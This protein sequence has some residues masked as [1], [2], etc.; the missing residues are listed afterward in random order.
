MTTFCFLDILKGEIL[1]V[2]YCIN[3]NGKFIR[4]HN[5]KLYKVVVK[6]Y[7]VENL[8][9]INQYAYMSQDIILDMLHLIFA[10]ANIDKL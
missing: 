8:K 6:L 3:N 1:R 10:F 5:R 9:G 4:I 2:F 7:V